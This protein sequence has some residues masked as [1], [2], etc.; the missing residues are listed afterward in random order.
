RSLSKRIPTCASPLT[1]PDRTAA[2]TA[3]VSLLPAGTATAPSIESGRVRCARTGSSTLLVA[4][5][6]A[7]SMATVNVVPGGIVTSRN[8]STGG[9]GGAAFSASTGADERGSCAPWHP[10]T[11][12]LVAQ[13]D[14]I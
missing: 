3:P 6:T 8:W 7:S 13:T 12:R 11:N 5:P 1:R 9:A 2:T 14:T 4:E 10:A